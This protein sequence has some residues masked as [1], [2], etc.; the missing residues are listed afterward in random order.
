MTCKNSVYRY[1]FALAAVAISFPLKTT[2][3]PLIGRE[4]SFLLF[5]AATIVST[6]YGGVGPGLLASFS[7]MLLHGG[8][9]PPTDPSPKRFSSNI[10]VVLLQSLFNH[11]SFSRMGIGATSGRGNER[12]ESTASQKDGAIDL[13]ACWN[14]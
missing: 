2:L 10:R 4:V 5:S 1:G 3:I 9:I 14:S 6:W 11:L 7:S 8:L 13:G 12:R